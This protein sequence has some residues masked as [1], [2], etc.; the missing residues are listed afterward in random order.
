VVAITPTDRVRR[1]LALSWGVIPKYSAYRE[2]IDEMMED[3]VDAALDADVARSGDTLVVLSGMM[4][5]LEGTNT[6][7]MLKLHVAAETVATGRKVVGGRTAGPL[8]VSRDG[9]LSDVPD[10]AILS[11]PADFDGEFD[12]DAA[13]LAGIIDA[14]PGMTGY[15]A[16]VA[17]E[18]DIPMI[19]GAP[20]PRR[21]ATGTTLTLHAERGVVYEG[22]LL[23]HRARG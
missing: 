2:G 16:L 15:P 3:A 10:G 19:S 21:L 20:L 1:Q 17:R 6:T 4:T 22:D 7:N 23:R 8:A 9:D 13:K 18:L 14:R 11:L 12:G 5:E